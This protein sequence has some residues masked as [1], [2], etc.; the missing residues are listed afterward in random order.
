MSVAEFHFFYS[1]ILEGR[2]IVSI[3][4]GSHSNLKLDS[5]FLPRHVIFSIHTCVLFYSVYSLMILWTQYLSLPFSSS[6]YNIACNGLLLNLVKTHAICIITV[7][8][9]HP[10]ILNIVTIP[11]VGEVVSLDFTWNSKL[12]CD[13]HIESVG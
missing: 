3:M 9:L 11:L 1:L 6:P 8:N 13:D 2:L 10:I 7:D 4:P 5:N 12:T